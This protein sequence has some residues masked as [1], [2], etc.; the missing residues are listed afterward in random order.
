MVVEYWRPN[1][2]N[3]GPGFPKPCAVALFLFFSSM[4]GIWFPPIRLTHKYV[5]TRISSDVY[6]AIKHP[7]RVPLFARSDS[8]EGRFGN[9]LQP[10]DC[11]EVICCC[12]LGRDLPPLCKGK[13]PSL[14]AQVLD[15]KPA[16][17]IWLYFHLCSCR[18]NA[19]I[20]K[21]HKLFITILIILSGFLIKATLDSQVLVFLILRMSSCLI[22]PCGVRIVVLVFSSSRINKE[23][24]FSWNVCW[25]L[26]R[27]L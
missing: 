17:R 23:S 1:L 11:F 27:P 25:Y 18:I 16:S 7:P 3:V 2:K 26:Y 15:T 6:M 8:S 10:L 24:V 13:V 20:L 9:S 21:E 22:S 4:F 14:K 12:V 5:H 19:Y